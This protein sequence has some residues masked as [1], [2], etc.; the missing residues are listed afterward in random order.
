MN[1]L[2]IAIL[3]FYPPESYPPPDP[4]YVS[5][6]LSNFFL[7]KDQAFASIKAYWISSSVASGFANSI[8]SLI[9]VLNRMGS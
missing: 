6:P 5:R 2:A 9:V 1:A 8:F 3:Y 7:M 4:T